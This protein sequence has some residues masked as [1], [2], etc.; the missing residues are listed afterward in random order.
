[1]RTRSIIV[2]LLVASLLL[3]PLAPAQEEDPVGGETPGPAGSGS[4]GGRGTNG[5]AEQD[6]DAGAGQGGPG[7]G[8]ASGRGDAGQGNATGRAAERGETGRAAR[9][10]EAA[11]WA[12][13]SEPTRAKGLARAEE[14]RLFGKLELTDGVAAGRFV[15]F[16]L[17][18][19]NV[20]DYTVRDVAAATS[21][22][23]LAGVNVTGFAENG[24]AAV[25]GAT[26]RLD[27]D[28][29][30]LSAHNN[31]TGLLTYRAENA[32]LTL[33]ILVP[34]EVT[35]TAE[36]AKTMQ[37]A[38][39][40]GHGHLI[41]HGNGTMQPPAPGAGAKL[42]AVTLDPGA[43]LV[44]M[45]HPSRSLVAQNLHKLR[46][47]MANERV[48]GI[49]TVVKADEAAI[50]DRVFLGVDMETT[51]LGPNRAEVVVRSDNPAGKVVVLNLDQT[52]LTAASGDNVAV[53]LDGQPLSRDDSSVVINATKAM[54]H[55]E[56]FDGGVQ[57]VVNVPAFSDHTVVVSSDGSSSGAGS[58]SGGATDNG[59]GS[60]AKDAPAA[61][62]ALVLAGVVFA[63]LVLA[64]RH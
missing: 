2:P 22:R 4:G 14:A 58:S 29:G 11:G 31:P 47:A 45:A 28:G 50:Q 48:G 38:P 55:V 36:S 56:R 6:T 39:L 3:L 5:T 37:L 52:V 23:F 54:Y 59:G 21:A 19:A 62:L 33:E 17:T 43:S 20:S 41:L 60:A 42:V 15:S 57:V 64:R 13:L 40:D 34:S 10:R 26:L 7:R 8:N 44:F 27:G 1:M 9:A 51:S 30:S 16:N 49:L 46:D 63:A 32:T 12:N 35:V 61:P 53:T 24:T 18:G 25:H